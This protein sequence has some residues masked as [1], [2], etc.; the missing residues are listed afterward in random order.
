MSDISALRPKLFIVQN[1]SKILYVIPHS[2][3]FVTWRNLYSTGKGNTTNG[4]I[5]VHANG[6]LNQMK[7]GV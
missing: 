7:T 5:M 2:A 4:Y 6:G 3:I 1:L